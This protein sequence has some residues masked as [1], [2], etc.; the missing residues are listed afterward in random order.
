MA[1]RTHARRPARDWSLKKFTK[2]KKIRNAEAVFFEDGMY[3]GSKAGKQL[4]D[5]GLGAASCDA[6]K[7]VIM[8]LGH[9][10]RFYRKARTRSRVGPE[11][12][13][14]YVHLYATHEVWDE[15]GGDAGPMPPWLRS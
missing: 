2:N 4:E 12:Y 3:A 10:H 14:P 8:S 5:G 15:I 11:T 9:A 13:T 1:L 7:G 6:G